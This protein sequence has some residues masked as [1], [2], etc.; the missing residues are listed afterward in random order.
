MRKKRI[1]SAR[2]FLE[3]LKSLKGKVLR[4]EQEKNNL[5]Y[6]YLKKSKASKTK[7]YICPTAELSKLLVPAVIQY[8]AGRKEKER[9]TYKAIKG[10]THPGNLYITLEGVQE[11]EPGLYMLWI[12]NQIFFSGEVVLLKFSDL[13]EILLLCKLPQR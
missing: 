6:L 5:T 1:I 4:I 7:T 11:S 13:Q 9:E 10:E 3:V 2:R 8:A 12:T